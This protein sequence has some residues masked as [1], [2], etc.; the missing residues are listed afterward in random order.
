MWSVNTHLPSCP[1]SAAA[2]AAGGAFTDDD[3]SVRALK[4]QGR[5]VIHAGERV[6][7]LSA[8]DSVDYVVVF[9]SAQLEDLIRTIQPDVLTKGSN[10]ASEEVAGRELVEKFGGRVVRIPITE[11]ISSTRIIETIRKNG[12]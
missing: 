8:L 9:A 3:D 5:P 12:K 11:D 1:R 4:G 7:I 2:S 6:R 10:Y